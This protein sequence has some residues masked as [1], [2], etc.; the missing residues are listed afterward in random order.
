MEIAR[1]HV[2]SPELSAYLVQ[3]TLEDCINRVCLLPAAQTHRARKHNNLK[4]SELRR[5][6]TEKYAGAFRE[7]EISQSLE[8]EE[9][10]L[11][12]AKSNDDKNSAQPSA[13]YSSDFPRCVCWE[14][15][16]AY[17]HCC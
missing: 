16:L 5:F 10:G 3:Q 8:N 14:A 13:S 9:E 12:G 11:P 15:R 2:L 4:V 1:E 6:R 17:G 7:V